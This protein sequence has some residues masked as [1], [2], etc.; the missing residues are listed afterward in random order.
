MSQPQT[1][2]TESTRRHFI[3]KISVAA[4]AAPHIIPASAIGADGNVAPS[5]RVTMGFI[6]VGGRGTGVMK[7]FIERSDVQALAVCDPYTDR[8]M[9]A[10]QLVEEEYD[11]SGGYKGC[12]AYNDFRELLARD[13]IDAV[14]I[15]TQDS[16]H[17]LHGIAAANAGKHTY[18][19]KPLSLT[20]EESRA[21]TK[22]VKRNKTLFQHGTQQRSDWKFRYACELVRNG[23]I[24]KLHTMRVGSPFSG[25][26]EEQPEEPIP[27]G[28][29]YDM[30]LG[31]APMRPFSTK[32]CITPWWWYISDYSIGFVAGWGV[33]HVDIA[34][35]G[36]GTDDTGPVEIEGCGVFPE[37]G[38]GDTATAWYLRLVYA[39]GVQML[40]TDNTKC[41]QGVRFEGSDGWIHVNRSKLEAEPK[42]LLKEI[43]GPDEIHLYESKHHQGNLIDCV[44]EGKETICP[45]ETAHRTMSICNLSQICMLLGRNLKWDPVKEEFPG[46]DEANKLR[47]REMR[48]PWKL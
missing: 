10:K 32:R 45:P 36:N 3:K 40:Y 5:E 15:A 4:L 7:R 34:Q 2:S 27:Q 24:G 23:R 6:G 21:L 11:E 25:R 22:A 18:I 31:P 8:R 44:K 29:D 1:P 38:I 13:D 33:H 9:A 41:E 42:S 28:F 47:S 14:S 17:V 20:I 30:W 19:E 16:W 37:S 26:L 48:A 39:N 35:W 12:D 43:I 46:D